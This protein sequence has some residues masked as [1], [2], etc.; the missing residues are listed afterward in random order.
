M[1]TTPDPDETPDPGQI[2]AD[3]RAEWDALHAGQ[4]DHRPNPEPTG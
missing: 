3:L 4:Y 1:S 2:V